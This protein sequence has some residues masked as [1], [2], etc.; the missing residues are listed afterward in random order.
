MIGDA[1]GVDHGCEDVSLV[2]GFA[3]RCECWGRSWRPGG[4]R[5]CCS[6]KRYGCEDC[7]VECV[8]VVGGHRYVPCE[9]R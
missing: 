3:G 7:D 2:Y 9:G 1:G 4:V 5:V 8:G 6:E